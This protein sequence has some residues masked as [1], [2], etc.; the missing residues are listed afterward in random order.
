MLIKVFLAILALQV[1]CETNVQE[2]TQ[3][4][5]QSRAYIIKGNRRV[6]H[7][8]IEAHLNLL[9]QSEISEETI[10]LTL[11]E[12]NY[13]KSVTAKYISGKWH[14]TVEE[15]PV[16][17]DVKYKV[18]NAGSMNANWDAVTGLKK[19]AFISKQTIKATEAV[20][21]TTYQMLETT[22]EVSVQSY[23]DEKDGNINLKFIITVIK[24]VPV[25][26][27]IFNGNTNLSNEELYE[28]LAKKTKTVLKMFSTHSINT[29]SLEQSKIQLKKY[30]NNLGY[31]DFEVKSLTIEDINNQ[32]QLVVNIYEGPQYLIN[33]VSISSPIEL[34]IKSSFLKKNH[35]FSEER[36]KDFAKK[37]EH[38]L[39]SLNYMNH[40]AEYSIKKHGKYVDIN[41]KIVETKPIRVGDIFINGNTR[42]HKSVILQ[43]ITLEPGDM[44]S[45]KALFESRSNIMRSGFC[46]NI[47]I[48]HEKI[49]NNIHD[50]TIDFKEMKTGAATFKMQ[51]KMQKKIEYEFT[52]GY[53]DT[54]FL[55]LGKNLKTDISLSSDSRNF[56]VELEEKFIKGK[57]IHGFVGANLFF[58][59]EVAD[60]TFKENPFNF[61]TASDHSSDQYTKVAARMK[62][63]GILSTSNAIPENNPLL[64]NDIA[65]K[66]PNDKDASKVYWTENNQVVRTK[67]KG[68]DLRTGIYMTPLKNHLF[69]LSIGANIKKI[70]IS[71]NSEYIN[72][73]DEIKTYKRGIGI[74]RFFD[75]EVKKFDKWKSQLLINLGHRF[76]AY[77]EK[78][79]FHMNLKSKISL[80]TSNFIQNTGSVSMVKNF[81]EKYNLTFQ[82]GGGFNIP[83]SNYSWFDNFKTADVRGFDHHGPRDTLRFNTLGGQKYVNA[84]L[85]FQSPMMLPKTFNA[86]WFAFLDAGSLWDSSLKSKQVPSSLA[87]MRRWD[88]NTA[89]ITQDKFNFVAS[90]GVGM[91]FKIGMFGLLL[92]ANY[93][94][95]G[96][97][98]PLNS[99]NTFNFGFAQ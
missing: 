89:D 77:N 35:H 69:S 39:Q 8:I 88:K 22:D 79:E 71:D 72:T 97:K 92:S 12:L 61:N 36:A 82:V 7:D 66:D 44:I 18:I 83:I 51:A 17:K 11:M 25:N 56:E 26:N 94:L 52:L 59:P 74:T 63:S 84:S 28:Q 42:T 64:A 87:D 19:R 60:S 34:N 95:Y 53:S 99:F 38:K 32:K 24:S 46:E 43:R 67:T 57:P 4:Q 93:P 98:S 49:S 27:A 3:T 15:L 45:N 21:K 54:N 90:C 47:D 31:V 33:D 10:T 96:S 76:A 20:L 91:Q 30:A 41:F 16:L 29:S 80:G 23:S 40:K 13:F 85:M 14:V 6:A 70:E 75:K 5:Q 9:N 50:L 68:I 81:N 48:N 1:Q 86:K 62:H 73:T 58:L 37:L 55:G 2:T 65:A 78:N